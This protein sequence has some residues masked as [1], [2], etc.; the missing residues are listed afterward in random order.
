MLIV[1]WIFNIA[2]Q[3]ACNKVDTF[4]SLGFTALGG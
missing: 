1:S 2:Y 3:D 4:K